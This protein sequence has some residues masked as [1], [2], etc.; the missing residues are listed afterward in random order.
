MPLR[1]LPLHLQHGAPL[2][3]AKMRIRPW[4]YFL[5]VI[6]ILI[7]AAYYGRQ[8]VRDHPQDFSF[9]PFKL[10]HPIGVAT[11]GK[12]SGLNGDF[13]SCQAILRDGGIAFET[14]APRGSASCRADQQTR[15]ARQ[16]GF[17]IAFS[18]ASVAP[19]CPVMTAL[20]LWQRD[21]IGPAA[22]AHFGRKVT[23]INNIGSY[24]CRNVAGTE[25]RS[26]HATGN[27]IDISGF[28][29]AGG[30]TISI[31][32]DWDSKDPAT[33]AFLRQVRDGSCDLFSTVLSPDYNKAHAD[34][35]HLDMA[36][37]TANYSMCR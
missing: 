31:L 24:N 13:N 20:V 17:P 33:R 32:K 35:F 6:A 21:V 1:C 9:M 37:R 26:E 18:P 4:L 36:Q 8:W 30:R 15:I 7:G 16:S 25:Y 10:S 11:H 28:T 12:L 5:S 19:S 27:A 14:L 22:E 3:T 2:T 23:R 29:L 34:H